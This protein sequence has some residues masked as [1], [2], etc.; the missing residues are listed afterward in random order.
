MAR[1]SRP[2]DGQLSAE[3]QR[4]WREL[5]RELGGIG[6]FRRGTLLQVSNRCGTPTC[7]CH[8]DP[9]R[10]HGPYWQWTR[11]VHG[12]TVTVSLSA[13]QAGLLRA[14]LDSG[15][16]LDQLLLE[17]EALSTTVTDRLL[18]AATSR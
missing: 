5:L 11:K 12:K 2:P 10:L 14:W 8:A 9:P 1:A 4:R 15:R 7:R 16:R 6:F 18:A 3:D 13:E 17:L